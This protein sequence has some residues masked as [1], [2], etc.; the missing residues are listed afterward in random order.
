[1]GWVPCACVCGAC[2]TFSPTPAKAE[3]RVRKEGAEM[4]LWRATR[5]GANDSSALEYA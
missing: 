1:M 4:P 5:E 3:P 2:L